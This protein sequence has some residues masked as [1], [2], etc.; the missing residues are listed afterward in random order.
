MK[1]SLNIFTFHGGS[2]FS[3]FFSHGFKSAFYS[4]VCAV[5]EY[6]LGKITLNKLFFSNSQFLEMADFF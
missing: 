2:V 3:L 4:N 1:A 5:F 6:F